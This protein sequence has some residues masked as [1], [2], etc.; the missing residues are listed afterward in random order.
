MSP[1]HCVFVVSSAQSDFEPSLT[2]CMPQ[3]YNHYIPLLKRVSC[4][5]FCVAL[6]LTQSTHLPDSNIPVFLAV[7]SEGYVKTTVRE[8]SVAA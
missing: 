6:C 7:I 3:L 8:E 1:F 4:C 2:R 5:S